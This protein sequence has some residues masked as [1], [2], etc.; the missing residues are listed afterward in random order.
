MVPREE[1][2]KGTKQACERLGC[3][4]FLGAPEADISAPSGGGPVATREMHVRGPE[5]ACAEGGLQDSK[6]AMGKE[7]GARGR[8]GDGVCEPLAPRA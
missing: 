8:A 6:E 3:R 1:G 4:S 5:P 2:F 7:S